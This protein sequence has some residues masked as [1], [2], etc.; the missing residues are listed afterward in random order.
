MK[1]PGGFHTS[2]NL[3]ST[4]MKPSLRMEVKPLVEAL[5]LSF[6]NQGLRGCP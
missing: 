2:R 3:H 5:A 1:I 6:T 4:N